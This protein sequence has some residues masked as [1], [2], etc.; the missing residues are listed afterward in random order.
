MVH[1]DTHTTIHNV[2][3]FGK[4]CILPWFLKD[5]VNALVQNPPKPVVPACKKRAKKAE[6]KA[7]AQPKA[8]AGKASFKRKAKKGNGLSPFAKAVAIRRSASSL[9]KQAK[10]ASSSTTSSPESSSIVSSP[11]AQMGPIASPSAQMDRPYA[12]MDLK[13]FQDHLAKLG[14]PEELFPKKKPAGAKSYTIRHDGGKSSLQVLWAKKSFYLT[15][16]RLGQPPSQPS[17][18]WNLYGSAGDAWRHCRNHLKMW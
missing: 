5:T 7:K 11:S 6:P 15:S 10:A 2:F 17:I 8:K 16:N 18:T 13:Q 3:G 9:L 12:E 4:Q 14:V 1:C